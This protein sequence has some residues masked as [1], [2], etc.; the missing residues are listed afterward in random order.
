MPKLQ[1]PGL[2]QQVKIEN[3]TDLLKPATDIEAAVKEL[4]S[5]PARSAGIA[6]PF[7]LQGP[8]TIL[9]NVM[10]TGELPGLPL[11]LGSE[12]AGGTETGDQTPQAA[13]GMARILRQAAISGAS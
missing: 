10:K 5:A 7:D 8:V 1:L 11:P 2:G 6:M 4:V 9:A 3:P 12:K 13:F